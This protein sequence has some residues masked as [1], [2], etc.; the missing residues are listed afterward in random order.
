MRKII[1]VILLV[2]LCVSGAGCA[3]NEDSKKDGLNDTKLQKISELA[4]IECYYQN[5]AKY[6]KE[7]ASK[8]LFWTKDEKFWIKYV[9]IAKIGIDATQVKLKVNGDKVKITVPPAKVLD[10]KVDADSLTEDSY[11]VAAHSAK[12]KAEDETAA[13]KEAQSDMEK[14]VNENTTLLQSAQERAKD[15][16]ENYVKNLGDSTGKEYQIEWVLQEK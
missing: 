3:N 6:D 15:L 4:A 12:T 5:V 13:L 7:N 11:I 1:A 8:F 10:C 9:G 14:A 16:L 2:C